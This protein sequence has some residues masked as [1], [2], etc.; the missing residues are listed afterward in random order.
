VSWTTFS[1]FS[2]DGKGY[3]L[4]YKT[5]T[6]KVAVDKLHGAGSGIVPVWSGWWSLGWA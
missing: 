2:I 3:Y 6:G 4:A 1:P 5:G